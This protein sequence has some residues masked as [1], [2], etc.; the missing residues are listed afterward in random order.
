MEELIVNTLSTLGF[1]AA[2]CLYLLIKMNGTL[3]KLT[4][5][6]ESLNRDVEKRETE[7]QREINALKTEYH[8]LRSII[9]NPPLKT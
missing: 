3:E 2:L 6:I 7:T 8:A 9:E 4:D 5:A 1:P